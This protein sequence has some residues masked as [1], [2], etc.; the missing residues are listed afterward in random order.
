MRACDPV[1]VTVPT[2][3]RNTDGLHIQGPARGIRVY[4]MDGFTSDD[5]TTYTSNDANQVTTGINIIDGPQGWGGSWLNCYGGPILD[6]SYEGLRPRNVLSVHRNETGTDLIDYCTVKD[7]RGVATYHAYVGQPY[8]ALA[9]STNIGEFLMQDWAVD[10]NGGVD[11]WAILGC[12]HRQLVIRNTTRQ[13]LAASVDGILVPDKTIDTLIIDG[14][15]IYETGTTSQPVVKVSAT[16]VVNDLRI[17][18][19]RWSRPG[20]T[21]TNNA[22]VAITGGTVG[23]VRVSNASVDR[24]QSLVAITGT[25]TVGSVQVN[26]CTHTNRNGAN[27]SIATATTV[28]ILSGAGNIGVT[29]SGTFTDQTKFASA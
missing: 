20:L 22:L 4:N 21:A 14:M 8:G 29:T 7:V 23:N 16:G 2:N 19:V 1:A 12:N 15:S 17:N 26:G 9:G 10:L 11:G 27:A 24:I 5:F 3:Y 6:C 18:N 25:P 13:S 28:P